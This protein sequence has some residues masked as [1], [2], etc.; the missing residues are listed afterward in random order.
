MKRPSTKHERPRTENQEPTSY[1]MPD[2][3]K[4]F[5]A[6]LLIAFGGPQRRDDIRPFLQ[7]V[8]RG[9][10]I[11]PERLEDV[12]RHYERL[13]GVSPIT[14]LTM[15]QAN[16]LAATLAARDLPLPVYVG[17]RNWHPLLVETLDAMARAG[18][19]RAIGVIAAAHRSYSSCGQ[20]RQ[21]VLQAQEAL[22]AAH[23]EAPR[24]FYTSDWHAHPGFVRAA[25]EGVRAARATLPD[26]LA[27]HTRVVFTAHSI[28]SHM[29]HADTYTRQLQESARLV[30]EELGLDRERWDVAYQSRSGRPN[31]PWLEPDING[32]LR[33]AQREGVRSVVVSPLGFACDH[34]EVLYDLD[35]EARA[36]C[37]ELGMIMARAT[38]VND[39]P[40]FLDALADAVCATYEC[41]RRGI[42]LALFDAEHPTAQELAPPATVTR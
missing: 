20:Y 4:P 17:M 21:N 35:H 2:V 18:V 13:G 36:T 6:V 14:E 26:A 12:A 31:D 40:A 25:A 24:L 38:A 42:P 23:R 8:V 28:P 39:H 9:R 41:Y 29:A 33:T 1:T 16:G 34:I 27:E 22:V 11:P 10:K 32:Y 7:N 5:D 37:K 19:R 15:R 30:A 3:S